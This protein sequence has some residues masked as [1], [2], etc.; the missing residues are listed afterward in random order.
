VGETSLVVGE[1]SLVVG[2]TSLVVGETNVL[3]P[4]SPDA[5]RSKVD[6]VLRP[7]RM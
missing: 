5:M 6:D 7:E 3:P 2:E 1:T 4:R